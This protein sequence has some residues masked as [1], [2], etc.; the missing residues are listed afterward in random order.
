MHRL[1]LMD[2]R[3]DPS[4]RWIP[5]ALNVVAKHVICNANRSQ[6]RIAAWRPGTLHILF[7]F[8]SKA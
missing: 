6:Q 7:F 8:V 4:S 3:N 5:E 2:P 1:A